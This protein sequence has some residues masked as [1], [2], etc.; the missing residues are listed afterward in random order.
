MNKVAE[1]F[2]GNKKFF[3]E[4]LLESCFS[5]E[6]TISRLGFLG[7][8]WLLSVINGVSSNIV[9]LILSLPIFYATLNITQKRCRD[10]NCKGTLFIL[11][12]SLYYLT[13]IC[14]LCVRPHKDLLKEVFAQHR[15]V[16]YLCAAVLAI[17]VLS[18]IPL[19]LIPGKKEK[20]ADLTSPLLKNRWKY[21][22]ICY[23]VYIIAGTSV[24]IYLF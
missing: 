18:L 20:D 22:G 4:D 23:A 7:F 5:S 9:A 16:P 8:L 12:Y 11:V 10:F 6:G 24:W 3:D 17:Y 14:W 1:K 19:L 13:H 15:Y 21:I 2:E